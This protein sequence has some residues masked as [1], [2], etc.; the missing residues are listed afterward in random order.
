MGFNVG[1][2][3]ASY[4]EFQQALVGYEK[5]TFVQLWKRDSRTLAAAQG[6]CPN[7][8]FNS[9]IKFYE[10][11]YSCVHG[12]KKHHSKSTGLRPN[13]KTFKIEC[14]FTLKLRAN[15]EGTHLLVTKFDN[16]HNHNVLECLYNVMPAQR[17]LNKEDKEKA[18]EMLKVNAD[19]KL[20]RHHLPTNSGKVLTMKDVHN[21]GTSVK[22]KSKSSCSKTQLNDIASYL[23]SQPGVTAEY[24]ADENDV[25]SGI[26]IQDASMQHTFSQFP[27]L[28][29][30]DA[31]H[32][33]NELRMP[34]Y[35]LTI[36]DGN[37]ETEIVAAFVVASEEEHTI[38]KMIQVFKRHNPRWTDTKVVMTDKDMVERNV[39]RDEIPN[40]ALQMCLFHVLRTFKRE[41]TT[42]KMAIS[43]GERTT[44]L[45]IIQKLAYATSEEEYNANY[46]NLEST[47]D[48]RVIDYY[49]INWKPITEQWVEGFKH[50]Q[51]SLGE[52]TN[53]R[54]ESTFQKLK[55]MTSPSNSLLEFLSVFFS[56][57]TMVRTERD[58]RVAQM[59]S[60]VPC[61][62][63]TRD[64]CTQQFMEYLT[65]HAFKRVEKQLERAGH[66]VLQEDNGHFS[67]T[68]SEGEICVTPISCDCT[69]YKSMS[70]PCRHIFAVRKICGR[71]LFDTELIA[72]RWTLEY[73]KRG[74]RFF[75]PLSD[76]V[77]E[78]LP[79]TVE[80]TPRPR[81]VTANDRYRRALY[82]GQQ[83]ASLAAENNFD[84][85]EKLS[86]LD[87]VV[88]MWGSGK[89]VAVVELVYDVTVAPNPPPPPTTPQSDEEGSSAPRPTTSHEDGSFA[90][91]PTSHEDGSFAPRPTTS[92]EDGS[93][94]PRP[95]T[96]HVAV[97]ELVYDMTAT[98]NPLPPTT[99][100]QSDEEGSFA[101]RPTTSDEEGSSAPRPTSTSLDNVTLP[102][103]SRKRGRPKGK[104]VN[105]IGLPSRKKCKVDKP[106]PFSKKSSVD[107]DRQI[108]S[109]FVG[110][111][112][113]IRALKGELLS[114]Q[115]VE[116]VPSAVPTAV[117]DVNI[118][119][120]KV[121]RYFDMDG[122]TAVQHVYSAVRS[123]LRTV[124]ALC[125]DDLLNTQSI[126]CDSCLRSLHLLCAGKRSRPKTKFWFCRNC[127]E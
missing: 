103:K 45:E 89:H 30:V 63:R 48:R 94:A 114:E 112:D 79:V 54:L 74:H 61:S 70:L 32:K 56:F 123:S 84:F 95:T 72:Q 28:I 88:K 13:Q 119:I 125:D 108:L 85:Q 17:R 73:Y 5:S 53:N 31:T 118:S 22:S 102:P 9:A 105:A 65:P 98:P 27:E 12:G 14:P 107:R 24:V 20:L 124:C 11:T 29:L 40:A 111:A 44:V 37:G 62:V 43:A 33:T 18:K 96:S 97:V 38:R 3:F 99:T 41:I 126:S 90:P 117:L 36:V 121:R 34:F 100:P 26:F 82:L 42:E 115:S 50:K 92:Q 69:F 2:Q 106:V 67:V 81:I 4:E 21:I 64:E 25:L 23:N 91:R 87:S 16:I 66:V 55:S 49:N 120:I 113:T 1:D 39:F 109:Y 52:R 104:V 7:R 86:V 68:S 83:L 60:K 47:Q 58:T 75:Q 8:K 122:W 116:Q 78:R 71:D 59:F 93:V 15:P 51:M 46:R 35:L 77:E 80:T 10:L 6:R 127:Y 76:I 101:P 110:E 57:L 19:R